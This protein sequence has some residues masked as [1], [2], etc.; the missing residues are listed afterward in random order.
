MGKI[1]NES[2]NKEPLSKVCQEMLLKW[3]QA[4]PIALL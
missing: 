2:Q 3:H 4:F 1:E